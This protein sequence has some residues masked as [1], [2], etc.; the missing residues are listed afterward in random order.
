MQR[1]YLR[2]AQRTKQRCQISCKELNKAACSLCAASL[3]GPIPLPPPLSQG[4]FVVDDV[5]DPA[6]FASAYE[7][8][9]ALR[10]AGLMVPGRVRE[11]T[12]LATFER[13]R[14]LL[15]EVLASNDG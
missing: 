14:H 1:R 4:F 10:A 11:F 7:G 8:A 9:E 12:D 3:V 5:A 6:L 15:V 13:A 2:Y